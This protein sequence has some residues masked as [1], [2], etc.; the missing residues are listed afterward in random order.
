MPR[1][2]SHSDYYRDRTSES[3]LCNDFPGDEILIDGLH[4]MQTHMW[5]NGV[6]LD[7]PVVR[8]MN[9][10]HFLAAYMFSTTCSGDQMEYDAL[11]NMSLG[12]D[13]QLFKV[14]IIVLAAMLKRTDGFRA[15]QCRN[16]LLDNRD[17]DFEEGVTLYDR[18]LHSAETRFEEEDFLIDTHTQIQK[19]IALNEQKD[20]EIATLRYTITTM[21]KQLNNTQY[22]NCVI[23][24]AEVYNTNTTNNYYSGQAQTTPEPQ[25]QEPA[26]EPVEDITPVENKPEPIQSIIFTKKAKQEGKEAFIIQALTKSIQGRRDKTRAFVKELQEW[27]NQG[28]VDA[29]YNAQVMY[30]ELAKLTSL[31]FGY[32]V[33]KKHYNNTRG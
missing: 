10:A 1:S 32:E 27:Q 28:Y 23:Y 33:F 18:F 31:P 25:A 29:H 5:N 15:Q 11:A 3:D 21:E 12:R 30:C 6:N 26:D 24:N 13:K 9:T 16:M 19:L 20:Q 8:I 2:F 4:A 7:L 14:A 22:N 17:A